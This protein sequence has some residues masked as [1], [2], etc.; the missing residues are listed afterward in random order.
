MCEPKCLLCKQ[1]VLI[2]DVFV[3]LYSIASLP[4]VFC[5][6]YTIISILIDTK[7]NRVY[8][9]QFSITLHH[10]SFS[11]WEF[12]FVHFCMPTFLAIGC[13]TGTSESRDLFKRRVRTH[14]L[15]ICD[16]AHAHLFKWQWGKCART[17]LARGVWARTNENQLWARTIPESVQMMCAIFAKSHKIVHLKFRTAH[18]R[19]HAHMLNFSCRRQRSTVSA[20]GNDRI[21]VC[22]RH[23]WSF[24]GDDHL[25]P[26]Q[27][28]W[29][30][31]YHSVSRTVGSWKTTLFCRHHRRKCTTTTATISGSHQQYIGCDYFL[32]R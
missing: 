11:P 5:N 18:A 20:V 1:D 12:V 4:T 14:N 16:H 27:Q 26:T 6:V 25:S 30:A 17:R 3:I 22:R 23:Q 8:V 2:Q 21:I 24:A 7:T 32:I 31:M 15:V 13:R 10:S 28:L 29:L 9:N 19:A